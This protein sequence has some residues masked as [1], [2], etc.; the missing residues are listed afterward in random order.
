MEDGKICV[1]VFDYPGT[2]TVLLATSS[3]DGVVLSKHEIVVRGHA[4][5]PPVPPGPPAPEPDP[6]PEPQPQPDQEWGKWAKATAEATV[7]SDTRVEQANAIAG[8]LKSLAAKIAAGGIEN[9]AEAR[10]E[11][12]AANARALGR[13]AIEWSEFSNRFSDICIDLEKKGDLKSLSQY[14]KIYVGVASGLEQVEPVKARRAPPKS[15]CGP[16]GCP[17]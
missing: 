11:L 15:P 4:P 9:P 6:L 3:V 17:T 5:V 7:S 12:R 2:Y 16:G 14:R 1:L 13:D 10:V 8:Q